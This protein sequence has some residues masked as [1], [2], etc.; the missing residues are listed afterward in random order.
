MMRK[1]FLVLLGVMFLAP[2]VFATGIN[3][4]IDDGGIRDRDGGALPDGNYFPYEPRLEFFH[5]D[6]PAPTSSSGRYAVD[7]DPV[8]GQ[9]SKTGVRNKYQLSELDGGTL[10]VRVWSNAVAPSSPGNNYYGVASHGVAAGLE[11]PRDWTM[12]I[13]AVYKADV[14]YTP[15]LGGITEAL[16]RTGDT[17]DMRLTIPVSYTEASGTERRQITGRSLDIVFPD[18]STETRG[19]SSITINDAP[20]GTY[21]FTPVA[22]N[23]WGSTRGDAVSYTTLGIGAGGPET[24]TYNFRRP[25]DA[26]GLNPISFPFANVADVATLRDLIEAINTQ[27]G[28]NIVTAAGWWDTANQQPTGYIITY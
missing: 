23:W 3:V 17:M 7:L 25:S 24:V 6:L 20:S 1:L 14:P 27:A 12:T 26:M 10:H 8:T 4:Y 21:S 5:N 9:Y 18:G 16:V 13:N 2:S 11:P 19:G 28:S 15:G 22:T